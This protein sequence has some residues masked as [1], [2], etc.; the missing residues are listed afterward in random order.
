MKK[1]EKLRKLVEHERHTIHHE[2]QDKKKTDN[3][4]EENE[5]H[6]DM[7]MEIPSTLFPPRD[8]IELLQSKSV[9]YDKLH[10]EQ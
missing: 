2:E 1:G 7:R 3:Y 9:N 5:R 10:Q 4:H 6:T 8:H